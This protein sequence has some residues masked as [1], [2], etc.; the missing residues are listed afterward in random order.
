MYLLVYTSSIILLKYLQ[1][2]LF[3]IFTRDKYNYNLLLE[4]LEQ[5]KIEIQP[6]RYGIKIFVMFITCGV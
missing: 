5:Q 2:Y 4:T 1:D 3:V 6:I